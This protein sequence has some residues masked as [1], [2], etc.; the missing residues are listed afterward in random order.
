MNFRTAL[1]S[2]ARTIRKLSLKILEFK[3]LSDRWYSSM[4]K[5]SMSILRTKKCSRNISDYMTI[6]FFPFLIVTI[7]RYL[8]ALKMGRFS[9]WKTPSTNPEKTWRRY[10]SPIYKNM[11]TSPNG[12]YSNP[13][14]TSIKQSIKNTTSGVKKYNKS[15]SNNKKGKVQI[16]TK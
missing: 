7:A 6:A 8:K 9:S 16:P 1:N 15:S 4:K 11:P 13:F 3:F 5:T 10:S 14:H 2:N 12:K